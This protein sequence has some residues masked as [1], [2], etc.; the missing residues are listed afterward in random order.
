MSEANTQ[1]VVEKTEAPAVQGAEVNNSARNDAGD[2][3]DKA[4]SEFDEQQPKPVTQAT[5]TQPEQKAGA[6]NDQ[7]AQEAPHNGRLSAIEK[8]FFKQD[9]DATIKQVRGD[10][11]PDLFDDSLVE[12]WINGE[13]KKDQRLATAWVNR[14]SN[15]AA[16]KKVVETLGR[17]F[18]K[19]Y[20]KLP[21]AKATEDREIVAAAVRGASTKAPEGKTPN[22]GGM[23][24]AEYREAHKRE[25]GYY[26]NV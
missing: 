3:L 20:A 24:N 8:R 18:A 6:T 17:N 2:D 25:Y 5:S 10:M 21:D 7:R 1:P 16:F 12:A 11:D 9:M 23:S 15:P 19:K 13:A 4:L 14:D 26:P 22:F